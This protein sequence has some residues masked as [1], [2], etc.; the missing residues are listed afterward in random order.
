MLFRSAVLEDKIAELNRRLANPDEAL[1]QQHAKIV[2]LE[3]TLDRLG[4][5][6]SS[7]RIT[8]AKAA[9]IK[10]D[11]SLADSLFAEVEAAEELA[12]HTTARAAFGRG[13]VA[14]A[15]IRWHDAARH[16]ARAAA[17]DP[18]F[19]SV[20]KASEFA[21]RSGD[22][23]AA[24][25]FSNQL[26]HVARDN[27][28]RLQLFSALSE[29]AI[30]LATIGR[31]AEA[32]VLFREALTIG[33]AT[34]G[35]LHPDFAACLS[36]LANTVSIQGRYDEV[37]ALYQEA[38]EIA[39]T[40][41]GEMHPDFAAYLSSLARAV[42]GQG[43]LDEAE[44]LYRRA[45]Q[46]GKVALGEAHPDYAI[47]LY[48][49]A[50]FLDAQDRNAEAAP[51]FAQSLSIRRATLGDKHTHTQNTARDFLNLLRAHNPTSPDIAVLEALLIPEP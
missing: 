25:L 50:K 26:L 51:L 44:L 20:R 39:R 37:E 42:Q 46:I 12:V 23:S 1:A 45:L 30:N 47:H 24:L 43:R 31:A 9:L 35:E 48:K 15:E 21:R 33:R 49:V 22:H 11:F 34:I 2:A 41:I 17:L 40:T 32:E 27:G 38:L 10:G 5:T 19:E 28:N 14:E 4:N 16:Y 7:D 8:A 18:T 13:E 29:H 3:E 6:V 36:N